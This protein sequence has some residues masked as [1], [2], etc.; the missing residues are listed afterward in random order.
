MPDY[1]RW[2]KTGELHYLPLEE[3]VLLTGSWDDIDG[4]YLPSM[5][6]DL[7]F[8]LV[9]QLTDEKMFFRYMYIYCCGLLRKK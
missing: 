7:C 3:K 4:V 8:N 2:R 5:V 6:L 9:Q 1:L